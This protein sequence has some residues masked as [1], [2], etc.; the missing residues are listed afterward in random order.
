MKQV[1]EG[2]QAVA[3]AVRL[4]R[5]EVISAYPIT[6][7]THII[8]FLSDY[9]ATGRLKARYIHVESEHSAMAALIGIGLV[10]M[11]RSSNSWAYF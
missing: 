3:E 4:A 7:Q 8:E 6:P 5:V 9:C 11:N 2:S 10:S 1:L